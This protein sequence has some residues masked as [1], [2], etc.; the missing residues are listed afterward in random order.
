MEGSAMF[1]PH[2]VPADSP[3]VQTLLQ[4]YTDVTGKPGKAF[5]IGGGTYVHHLKNGV[6]FDGMTL[7]SP[8][9][10]EPHFVDGNSEFVRTLL[11]AYE[12]YTG[13][14]GECNY[15]GGGT[16]VHDLKNGVAFGASMPCVD[17]RMH[18]ADEFVEIECL[19][20]CVVIFAEAI[21]RICGE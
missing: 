17:N 9:L 18:G 3:F 6:A 7:E 19:K 2:H 12:L 13:N 16:Y 11:N 5:A 4:C 14:K 20:Q 21:L 1:P 15:T 8:Q 10:R